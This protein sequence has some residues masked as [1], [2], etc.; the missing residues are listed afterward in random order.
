M[1][2]EKVNELPSVYTL[3]GEQVI[4]KACGYS[5]TIEQAKDLLKHLT[6]ALSE[7]DDAVDYDKDPS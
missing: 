3:D 1:S 6:E 7:L 2:I 4:I 5:M